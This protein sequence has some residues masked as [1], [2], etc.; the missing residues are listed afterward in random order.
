MN[1][2]P[3]NPE[4]DSLPYSRSG[5]SRGENR[6]RR[7]SGFRAALWVLY[8]AWLVFQSSQGTVMSQGTQ[9]RRP[10]L[11]PRRSRGTLGPLPSPLALPKGKPCQNHPEHV[12]LPQPGPPWG[13]SCL[14][15][16]HWSLGLA[17]RGFPRLDLSPRMNICHP[18]LRFRAFSMCV[19]GKEEKEQQLTLIITVW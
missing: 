6:E 1:F 4:D 2:F 17:W 15:R 7:I 18:C 12:L 11:Q 9:A 8:F 14:G 19:R 5:I 10:G 16:S 3:Q 13:C